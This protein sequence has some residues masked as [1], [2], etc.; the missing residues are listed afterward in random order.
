MF[1]TICLLLISVCLS[2]AAAAQTTRAFI[3]GV[4]E[5]AELADL[6]EGNS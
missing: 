1:R 5:Y 3:V 6:Q 2:L 4:G